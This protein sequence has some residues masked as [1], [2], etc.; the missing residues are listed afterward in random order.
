[1]LIEYIAELV[2][3]VLKDKFDSTIDSVMLKERIKQFIKHKQEENEFSSLETEI[4]FEGFTDYL[5]GGMVADIKKYISSP[6][7][8]RE[9][10]KKDILNKVCRCCD[11]SSKSQVDRVKTMALNVIDIIYTFYRENVDFNSLLLAGE[12]QEYVSIKKEEIVETIKHTAS[13]IEKDNKKEHEE[14]RKVLSDV[15]NNL[16]SRENKI[17]RSYIDSYIKNKRE[18]VL[19]EAIFPWYKDSLRYREV[20]PKLFIN[21]E[22]VKQQSTISFDE[23]LD[24]KQKNIAILG[25]A[26]AGKSTLLRYLFA[27]SFGDMHN[28]IY[29]K[30]KE[31]N[32]EK[33]IL[34]AII[35]RA[36]TFENEQFLVFIDG[37]DEEFA[38][39][40]N[41]LTNLMTKLGA[42][43][44]I[45]FWLGCR[46]DYYMR[47]YSEYFSQFKNDFTIKPWTPKQAES[48]IFNYSE[49]QKD[50]NLKS[51]VD[52]LIGDSEN[53]QQL[54]YNPFLL[55]LLVFLA[56]NN[57]SEPILGIYNLYERFI[58][59]WNDHEVKR[60]TS[61]NDRIKI[62]ER[63]NLIAKK[64][65]QGEVHILDKFDDENSAV[66]NLLIINDFNDIIDSRYASAFHHRSLAAFLLAHNLV[67]AFLN[68][69]SSEVTNMLKYKLK[70][71]VTNFIGDKFSNLSEKDKVKIKDNLISLY[72][73]TA[74][75]DLSIKEQIIYYI[76][77][78]GIDVSD[79]L[80][81]I[82]NTDIDHPIMRL[83]AA[84]G[85]VLS[86]KPCIRAFALEYA[87]S[88]SN[89]TI[90]AVTNRAWTVIYFGDVNDKDPYTYMDD[91][92]RPWR[93]ARKARIKRF[94]KEKPRLKDYRFRLF[95]IPLF[96]SFLINRNWND[97]SKEEFEILEKLQFPI[98]IFNE[99]ERIFL[100]TEKMKLLN[101]YR[102]HLKT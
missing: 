69:D 102:A 36:Q 62:I 48:F 80:S 60:G 79:F 46:K 32:M 94:T 54:K 75:S 43:V 13:Y 1:M 19:D 59:K 86:E 12:T 66:R 99:E 100:E 70:D 17:A 33:S 96:R 11:A 29:I 7:V 76:T 30:A 38:Y 35:Q 64:I 16:E 55:S 50:V 49:I 25:E 28:C 57:E 74:D 20:F 52:T 92:K 24:Y 26:G 81:E 53:N 2:F 45:S 31:A 91:E 23:L 21:P 87:K 42:S 22:L 34:D 41:A 8:H 97:L 63:L 93:N 83:T 56:Q 37:I 89:N 51:K 82:I 39:D 67:E 72:K 95:D 65:Y 85:C 18:K 58:Q 68:N 61:I 101:D 6:E 88:I 44:N 5:K 73:K 98:D 77:R 3:D 90:D 40:Y 84:Y 78:L 4:D 27:F 10:I 14:T 47:N 9:R 15:L 71:D